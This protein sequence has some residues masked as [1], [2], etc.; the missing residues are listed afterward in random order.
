MS[1]LGKIFLYLAVAGALAAVFG[2]YEAWN[3]I[4]GDKTTIVQ[5]Q[6]ERDAAK[7]AADKAKQEADAAI[8][9]KEKAVSDLAADKS[10]MDELNASLSTAQQKQTELSTQLQDAKAS[11]ARAEQDLQHVKD[12]FNGMTP[13]QAKAAMKKAQ[14]DLLANQ[15]EQKILQDQL[16]STVK[17]VEDLKLAINR[18]KTGDM[19]PGISGKVTFIN[20]SWNFVVMNVGL[21]NGVVPNGELWIY[22]GNNMLG[23]V[24]VTSAEAST[25]VADI[26]P[27]TKVDIQVGDSVIN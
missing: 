12:I 14:D 4:N 5:S 7:Q 11:V 23:K 22:R 1:K 2:A 21:S 19:P 3:K 10:K 17:Q 8:Q 16:Q 13:D 25:S 15:S 6:Q 9:D 18:S 20:R 26:L 24:K 27:E